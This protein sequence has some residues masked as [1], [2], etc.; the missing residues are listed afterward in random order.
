MKIE[1]SP[2]PKIEK[3]LSIPYVIDFVDNGS[4]GEYIKEAIDDFKKDGPGSAYMFIDGTFI[5]KV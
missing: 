2:S 5:A 1:F 4:V 3:L